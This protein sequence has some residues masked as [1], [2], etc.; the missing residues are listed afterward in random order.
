MPEAQRTIIINTPP[1]VLYS[2]ITDYESYPS[3]LNEVERI[4]ILS[5][6]DGASGKVVRARYTVRVIK[7]IQYVIDLTEVENTSVRW[8]LVESSIMRSNVGGWTLRELGDGRTEA[9]YGLD[10]VPKGV[11][12]PRKIISMLTDQTLPST[13]QAFKVRAESML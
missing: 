12:V 10:V 5:R 2:V 13:L 8:N 3:F 11:F 6:T 4:E 9:T 7:T 1:S